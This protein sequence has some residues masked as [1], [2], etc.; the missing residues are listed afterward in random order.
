VHAHLTPRLDGVGG[1]PVTVICRV[2]ARRVH[3]RVDDGS[4]SGNTVP[5]RCDY[6]LLAVVPQG[7]S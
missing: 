2:D 1:V 5:G 6:T 7:G 4:G 3:C